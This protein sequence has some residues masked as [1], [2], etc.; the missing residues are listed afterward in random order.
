VSNE[1]RIKELLKAAL[2]GEGA[3]VMSQ[4]VGPGAAFTPEE[5]QFIIDQL[6]RH[7]GAKVTKDEESQCYVVEYANGEVAYTRGVDFAGRDVSDLEFRKFI[8]RDQA[9]RAMIKKQGKNK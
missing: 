3:S 6:E 9:K 1:S 4:V 7:A 5:K 8:K 2:N